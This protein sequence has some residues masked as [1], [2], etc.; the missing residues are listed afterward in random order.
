MQAEQVFYSGLHS[1]QCDQ[2][3]DTWKYY[4]RKEQV[5]T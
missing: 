3:I 2:I 1:Q 4:E 5:E